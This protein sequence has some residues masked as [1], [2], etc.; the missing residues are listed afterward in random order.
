MEIWEARCVISYREEAAY[1]RHSKAGD[2]HVEGLN[3][4]Q[5]SLFKEIGRVPTERI[6][7]ESLN[8]VD[9][10]D[11]HCSAQ[12]GTLKASSIRR[13][14]IDCA[15][16]LRCDYHQSNILFDIEVDVFRR[17]ESFYHL[18]GFF[19]PTPSNEPPR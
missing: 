1:Y 3:S 17:G 5:A 2:G 18:S 8:A 10:N 11:D 15:L 6:A 4:G 13:L 7:I 12:I 14:R 19:Q 16:E 9:A